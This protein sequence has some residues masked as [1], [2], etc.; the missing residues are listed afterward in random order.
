MR[1]CFIADGTST[2]TKRWVDYF[3]GRGH[4]VHLISSR[5]TEGYEGFDS[6]IQMHLLVKL[7]PELWRVS[8]YLSGALWLPQVR[9]LV[10]EIRPD[11]LNAHYI[12]VPAYLAVASGFHPLVLTAWGSDILIDAK[13]N[14]IRRFLT[15]YSLKKA[16]LITCDGENTREEMVRLGANVGK[17]RLIYHG[18]DT[19]KFNPNQRE[20]RLKDELGLAISPTIISVRMLKPIY[21]VESL[22]KAMPVVIRRVPEAKLIIG[23]DGE[24][25]DYLKN[26]ARSLGVSSAI[27]FVGRIPHDELPKYIASADV[28]VSTSLSDGGIAVSTLEAMASGLPVVVTDCGDISKW[29]T[30]GESGF[31]VPLKAPEAIAAKVGYLLESEE[32]RAEF[33][34]LAREVVENRADYEKEMLKVEKLY[35]ELIDGGER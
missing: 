32:R 8:A 4:E 19:Q 6:R 13:Q 2:H 30:D 16:D 27:R 34:R 20:H 10:R 5:F 29:I 28:Y 15:G 1:L 23:G 18:V 26:L 9:R 17:I 11:V 22:V 21:D 14:G 3:A 31:I 12:G 35:Q 33:G 24:Q 25:R 7:V